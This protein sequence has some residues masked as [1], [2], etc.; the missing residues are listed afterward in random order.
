VLIKAD[1][2]NW[3]RGGGICRDPELRSDLLKFAIEP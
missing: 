1:A 3:F 2:L